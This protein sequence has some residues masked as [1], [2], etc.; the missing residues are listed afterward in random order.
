VD[1]KKQPW[2]FHTVVVMNERRGGVHHFA[3]DVTD[4]FRQ[5]GE[6]GQQAPRFL[7]IYPQPDD[8]RL[9]FSG[10]GYSDFLPT[11][12]PIGPVR[13]R[14]NSASGIAL[15]DT[16]TAIDSTGNP[17][18]YH[19]RWVAFLSGGFDPQYLKGRGVHMV[20][21][22]TGKEIFDFSYPMSSSGLSGS[23]PR[24]G[25]RYPV[26]ATVAM[27]Q[28]GKDA[29]NLASFA[30]DGYFDTATFGDAG[31]QVW[32]LRFNDPAILD[33]TTKLATNWLG[34]RVFQMGGRGNPLL[35][36]NEPFFYIAANVALPADGTLRFL[37]GTGDRY[38]LLDQYGGTCGPD[39]IRACLQRGCTVTLEGSSNRLTMADLG[40]RQ[41][42]LSATACGTPSFSES[43]GTSVA[44]T[45]AGKGK[46]VISCP[47]TGNN[48]RT[49]TKDIQYACAAG[50]GGY[51]CAAATTPVT[52]STLALDDASNVISQINKFA[53]IRVFELSGTRG[54]FTT[55]A[56]A[57]A[58]DGARLV[59][60]DLVQIDGAS[61]APATLSG[62]GDNGWILNFNHTPS[63][64]IDTVA[65][66]VSRPDERVSSTSAVAA[67]CVLWN[68]TQTTS[69]A[70]AT[71]NC[72]VSNCKQ[73]NRRIHYLY[74]A[75]V[76]TGGLC[77]LS[78]DAIPIRS[79]PAVAL[80]PPPAPQYTIFINQKGQ[81][82][83]GMTSVNTEIGAKN[84]SAG[85]AIDPAALL[86]FLD[87]PPALHTCRHSPAGGPSPACK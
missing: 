85:G 11:P 57:I 80:V 36:T 66:T 33:G 63:V 50:T 59:D 61:T 55:A 68:T 19:E 60:T 35:C 51:G 81:V 73:I 16:P 54:L 71:G 77:A 58:Y 76:T 45:I 65:Y 82:Q 29:R 25:L 26:P 21:V 75:D 17:V 41:S 2:E 14:A 18:R 30:N 40:D 24:W 70:T 4:A 69:A 39:N 48:A 27:L 32:V 72:F 74:A 38:N 6:T 83:V 31:G 86:E 47:S 79:T 9:L 78:P 56:Q 43:L 52:G 34:A 10:E 23:D 49:T 20:D 87:V 84:V 7:W 8:P 37:A 13:V 3:L 12:P 46:V 44:C 22:W 28:W 5:G 53:S 15:D 67:N 1:D 42:G 64:T 62:I